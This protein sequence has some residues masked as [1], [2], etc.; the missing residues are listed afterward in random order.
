MIRFHSSTTRPHQCHNTSLLM[1]A[2]LH[3][4]L[5][6]T[7]PSSLKLLPNLKHVYLSF[8]RLEGTLQGLFCTRPND[9]ME[10]R[11]TV[12]YY[13]RHA[14][15]KSPAVAATASRAFSLRA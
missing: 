2:D 7:I 3:A 5:T 6:G 15:R 8:N 4:G 9:P 1:F 11:C 10:V 14:C 12:T 13:I